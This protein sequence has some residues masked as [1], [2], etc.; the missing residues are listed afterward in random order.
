MRENQTIEPY[1]LIVGVPARLSRTLS[2]STYDTHCKWAQKYI[3]LAERHRQ[4]L[5]K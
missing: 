3:A 1:S 4:H 2:E 5:K